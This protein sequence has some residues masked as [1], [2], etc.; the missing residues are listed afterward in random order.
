VNS[1]SLK[2]KAFGQHNRESK[3]DIFVS[4]ARKDG[5]YA[6]E[7]SDN[8]KGLKTAISFSV[9]IDKEE[10]RA[11]DDL[12]NKIEG[13]LH[14]SSIF[15]IIAT[16]YYFAS[17]WA[18]PREFPLIKTAVVASAEKRIITLVYEECDFLLE[19][20]R[21]NRYLF[22]NFSRTRKRSYNK[23]ISDLYKTISTSGT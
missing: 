8:L 1:S 23:L 9:F 13:A 18:F 19:Y 22:A 14:S 7:L 12:K 4:Y 20:H 2:S 17:D 15:I 3:Y 10:L 21:L 5:R 6:H 16:P 11:G